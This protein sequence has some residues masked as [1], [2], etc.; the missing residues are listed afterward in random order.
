[1][2]I[3]GTV[4]EAATTIE[5]EEKDTPPVRPRP[6][7]SRVTLV[8]LALVLAPV[9]AVCVSLIGRHYHPGGDQA[10]ELLRIDDVGTKHTPLLGPWSR[11]GW[12]HPGPALFWLL[13]P[14]Y[15]VF[16]ETG[17]PIG[18]G[19]LNGLAIVGVIVV[20]HRR[21]GYELAALAGLMTALLV[22]ALGLSLVVDIWNPWAAFLPF[23]LFL[24]LVWSAL[25]RDWLMLPIAV[26]VGSCVVQ[27]HAGYLPLVGPLLVLALGPRSST[28]SGRVPRPNSVI[29]RSVA[30]PSLAR[31][32]SWSGCRRWC[33]S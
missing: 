20:A 7:S 17:V 31:S 10:L 15:R 29:G 30:S 28:S 9:V 16:G 8:V 26:F 14:F 18:M 22:R 2:S 13:T 11:W 19:I 5:S 21:G 25:C 33:S 32:R 23:V 12:A 4:V 1:M 27:T 3:E 6:S 24:M